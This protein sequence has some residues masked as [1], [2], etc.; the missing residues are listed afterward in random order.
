MAFRI[1]LQIF[2][3]QISLKGKAELDLDQKKKQV[4]EKNKEMLRG[5]PQGSTRPTPLPEYLL[6]ENDLSYY[7]IDCH[8]TMYADDH[9]LHC[10]S[11]IANEVE[12]IFNEEGKVVLKWYDSNLLQGNSS[13]SQVIS[14][15]PPRQKKSPK[16]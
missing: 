5:C 9:Q 3:D 6:F 14:F 4:R 7:V 11:K 13:K 12:N 8:L 1:V 15:A 16:N 2:Y 10:V